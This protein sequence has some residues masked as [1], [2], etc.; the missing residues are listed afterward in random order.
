MW[1]VLVIL[2]IVPRVQ[3][4]AAVIVCLMLASLAAATLAVSAASD[5]DTYNDNALGVAFLAP[6]GLNYIQAQR[7]D[8]AFAGQTTTARLSSYPILTAKRPT[9]YTNQILVELSVAQRDGRTLEDIAA[10][11][12]TQLGP[13][14]SSHAV[15]GGR[16]ALLLTGTFGNGPRTFA[17]VPLDAYRILVIQAFPSYSTRIGVF[18]Q[19]LN[20]LAI[21]GR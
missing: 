18:A 5:V 17:L 10:K 16:E 14:T 20:T 3:S 4:R 21:S 9:D 11:R 7:T 1:R 6:R 8:S 13:V 15:V 2:R 19:V 12:L